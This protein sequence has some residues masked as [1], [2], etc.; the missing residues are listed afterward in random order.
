MIR[1]FLA[2]SA[3][4]CAS[5]TVLLAQDEDSEPT[6]PMRPGDE[7]GE[8]PVSDSLADCAS[9]LAVASGLTSNLV[10]R[11]S[12]SNAAG[13]WFATSG[14]VALQEGGLPADD[15]W[16]KKVFDWS[17]QLSSVDGMSGYKD[18]MTYC[19]HIGGE[20][21]LDTSLFASYAE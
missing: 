9:I 2:F 15:L 8:I 18:W 11:N 12:Y 4:L 19:V 16:E 14:D 21:G 20:H 6:A 3:V 10:Y 5:S 17:G 1:T 7:T 13:V